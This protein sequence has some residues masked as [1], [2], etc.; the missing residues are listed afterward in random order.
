MRMSVKRGWLSW[1]LC[2][3][4]AAAL[5]AGCETGQGAIAKRIRKDEA[6]FAALPEDDQERLRG[7]RL[8]VGDPLEAARIVYG[9]PTQT[10][11]HVTAAGTNLVWSYRMTEIEPVSDFYPVA[12][13]VARR[14]GRSYWATDFVWQRSYLYG[15]REFLRIEFNDGRVVAIDLVRPR[16]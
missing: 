14:H 9:E 1:G 5:V 8:E 3:A 7:G 12:Y 11:E 4:L 6:F 2:G 15:S 16:E 10:H 13:P